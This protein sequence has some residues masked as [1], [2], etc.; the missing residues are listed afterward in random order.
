MPNK[1]VNKRQDGQKEELTAEL[2]G[3]GL[4]QF[5]GYIEEE[6]LRGLQN[7]ETKQQTFKEMAEND[8]TIGSILF[9]LEML[10]RQVSWSFQAASDEPKA[11]E[12]KLFMEQ[13]L[14]DMSQSW[15]DTL[16]E[17]VTFWIWG[18]SLFEIVYKFRQGFQEEPSK[19][20]KFND[21]K[22]GWR[23][24]A[25]RSQESLLR[26]DFDEEQSLRGM[27]QTPAPTY[28]EYNIPIEKSLLFR[29]SVFKGNPEGKSILRNM[30]TTYN[31]KKRVETFEAVGIE[32]DLAG[33]PVFTVPQEW[34]SANAGTDLN[35]N[36][37]AVKK[38]ARR[39]KRD[40][41]EGLVIPAIYD[42]EGNQIFKF[43]LVSSGGKRQFDTNEIINRLDNRLAMT[44]LANFIFTGTG[45]TGSFALI[46]SQT[47][48][49]ATAIESYLDMIAGVF[50]RHA[51]PRLWALNGFDMET[52]PTLVPGDV[53]SADLGDLGNY[54]DKLG[55]LGI[56]LTDIETQNFLRGEGGL[57]LIPEDTEE[58]FNT[59]E[60]DD[61][62]EVEQATKKFMD[63]VI[64]AT[65]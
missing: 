63:E 36:Y 37:E 21:N 4:I 57:P 56:N 22:I 16:S 51:I 25:I 5:G 53:E 24:L 28:H 58:D 2:G 48:V 61:E 64:K 29:T 6:G 17:I 8:A 13:V 59:R 44:V 40:E 19:R 42:E 41:Q 45:K 10:I 33:Y 52:M 9:A 26:W 35:A 27:V 31:K 3:T 65:E 34:T 1:E 43:E 55:K 14:D 60:P 7:Q 38:V 18:W 32:R 12:G 49:F 62:D 30:Y 47:E 23:K 46:D 15:E 50:N 54:L 39:I 20:S 11:E